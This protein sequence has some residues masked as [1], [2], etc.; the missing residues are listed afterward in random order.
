MAQV[1]EG[2]LL[3]GFFYWNFNENQRGIA[4]L[5]TKEFKKDF[6]M[7]PNYNPNLTQFEFLSPNSYDAVWGSALALNCTETALKNA[8]NVNKCY[9]FFLFLFIS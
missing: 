6:R 5:T 9:C 4:N 2:S 8:G 1:A 7:Q 3:T